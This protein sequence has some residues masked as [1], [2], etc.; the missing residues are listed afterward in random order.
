MYSIYTYI[1]THAP[2]PTHITYTYAYHIPVT[3]KT[4]KC[5]DVVPNPA[6]VKCG[7][8][9]TLCSSL[10]CSRVDGANP[11]NKKEVPE[12]LDP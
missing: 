3:I 11:P 4:A 7:S 5:H 2:L 6:Q 12:A 8:G 10:A 1:P 9:N